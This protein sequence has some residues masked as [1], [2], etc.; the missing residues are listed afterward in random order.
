MMQGA[1]AR[2]PTI[3]RDRKSR[4]YVCP[5]TM[6]EAT[7]VFKGYGFGVRAFSAELQSNS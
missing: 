7:S 1:V 4:P 5:P 6:Q 2:Q 3:A